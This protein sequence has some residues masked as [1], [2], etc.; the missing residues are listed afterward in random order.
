MKLFAIKMNVPEGLEL[1]IWKSCKDIAEKKETHK[2]ML[3]KIQD[4]NPKAVMKRCK[5]CE[6]Y[7]INCMDYF[8]ESYFNYLVKHTQK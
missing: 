6:G 5:E 1:C 3:Q 2:V 8:P 4:Y 7:D